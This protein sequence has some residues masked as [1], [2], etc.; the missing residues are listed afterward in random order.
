LRSLN[1]QFDE[2]RDCLRVV[3]NLALRHRSK[4]TV[5]FPDVSQALLDALVL[6][7]L[8]NATPA[9]TA[10][11]PLTGT[12]GVG[13]VSGYILAL[14][15]VIKYA[16]APILRPVAD[17]NTIT[18]NLVDVEGKIGGNVLHYVDVFD[19]KN[20]HEAFDFEYVKGIASMD[21]DCIKK[22]ALILL[23]RS[24]VDIVDLS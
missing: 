2:Y 20:A 8:A 21:F 11:A 4:G 10:R 18:W 12:L 23:R 15:V 13:S 24:D 1:E 6:D 19:W 22:G 9:N 5:A 3:W 17:E 7:E 14:G 16:A